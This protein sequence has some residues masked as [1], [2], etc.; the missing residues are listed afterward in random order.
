MIAWLKGQ[1]PPWRAELI[2]KLPFVLVAAACVW[3]L[4]TFPSHAADE[5]L[6]VARPPLR[7]V[8]DANT[9]RIDKLAKK[10][11]LVRLDGVDNHIDV[12]NVHDYIEACLRSVDVVKI[13]SDGHYTIAKP[14]EPDVFYLVS[15]TKDCLP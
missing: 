12:K 2:V 4:S 3:A 1:H 10:L 13:D 6:P 8:V 15:T 9:K 11:E 7:D 14:D 5:P